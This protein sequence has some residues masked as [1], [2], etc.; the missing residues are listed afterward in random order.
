MT[1]LFLGAS[2]CGGGSGEHA[3]TEAF[4]KELHSSDALY[5]DEGAQVLYYGLSDGY[6]EL[7]VTQARQAYLQQEEGADV[8]DMMIHTFFVPAEEIDIVDTKGSTLQVED[9]ELGDILYVEMDMKTYIEER[10]EIIE[11]G[12][13]TAAAD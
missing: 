3:D 8:V 9:L 2:G 5:T 4:W 13:L 10:P 11:A 12:T 1:A 6:I 7:D